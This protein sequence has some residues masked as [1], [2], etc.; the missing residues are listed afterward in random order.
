MAFSKA[1]RVYFGAVHRAE[2]K[3]R[4]DRLDTHLLA[5]VLQAKEVSAQAFDTNSAL[6]MHLIDH[7]G[8]ERRDL[9]VF[10]SNGSFDGIPEALS[11]HLNQ[12]RELI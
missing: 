7:L 8:S 11:R 6:K 1:D 9:F 4:E 3:R 2:H 10:F 12:A 5:S